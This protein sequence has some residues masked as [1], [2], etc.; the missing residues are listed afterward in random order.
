MKCVTVMQWMLYLEDIR[1]YFVHTGIAGHKIRICVS[2]G[3]SKRFKPVTRRRFHLFLWPFISP[4]KVTVQRKGSGCQDMWTKALPGLSDGGNPETA[5]IHHIHFRK[6]LLS[7]TPQ[8]FWTFES[9][10]VD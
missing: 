8:P 5:A 3:K 2:G 1:I 7:E 6:E 10:Q 9:T 4:D